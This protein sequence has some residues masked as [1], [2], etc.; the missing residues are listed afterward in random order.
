MNSKEQISS[1]SFIEYKPNKL[2]HDLIKNHKKF[3]IIFQGAEF[4]QNY[5]A[6]QTD[7][8]IKR[9][10]F[11]SMK[12]DLII[13]EKRLICN[14]RFS[15]LGDRFLLEMHGPRRGQTPKTQEELRK[16]IKNEKNQAN[17][18]IDEK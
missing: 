5:G 4:E 7:Y 9:K 3:E 13:S 1:A 16:P 12:N 11:G 14:E 2:Y 18:K 6:K 8:Y 10:C 17:E 15:Y